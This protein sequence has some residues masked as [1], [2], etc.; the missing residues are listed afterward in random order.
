MTS[1]P[2]GVQEKSEEIIVKKGGTSSND[3]RSRDHYDRL[4]A[5]AFAEARRVVA[6][7]GVVTIV[8]GH[9]EP[10]VWHRLLQAIT[11]A[12]LYLTGS[13][14]AKTE[15]GGRAGSANI[16]TTLTMSCRPV[17]M[18]RPV[19][20]ANVVEAEVRR[21]IK[22]RVPDWEAAGLAPTDQLMASAGPAME[23]VGQYR[24]VLDALGEPVAPDRYLLV[25]RRA[26]EE[27]AAIKVDTLPL[28]AFDARTRFALGWVRLYARSVAPKSEAR[29]QAL[30]SNLSLDRL[31]GVLTS[32]DKG[33]RLA[34]AREV[35]VQVGED[36]SVI[37][38][39]LG[40]AGAWPE[41]LDVVGQVLAASYRDADDPQLW[42]CL[43]Y[44]SSKLP[45]A[46]PDGAVWTSL[47]RNRRGLE[48]AARNLL[49]TRERQAQERDAGPRQ[50]TLFGGE[51]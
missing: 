33:V 25:A 2:H 36:S 13:W 32:V 29:W 30:A 43:S 46:D 26:V 18:N 10:E 39:A 4:I 51:R 37:D 40:L 42:A 3:H 35:E 48:A 21:E 38:V 8:F 17:P 50:A 28:E 47:L 7:D 34:L 16:V 41:G 5:R 31:R 6:D 22:R 27:A 49:T 11:T 12:G 1:D 15:K 24:E 19:G 14:P 44:L 23:V 45:E 9:G 20:K